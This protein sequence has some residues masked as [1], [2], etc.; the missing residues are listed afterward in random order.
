[1]NRAWRARRVTASVVP[2]VELQS[3]TIHSQMT[4][5]YLPGP[6]NESNDQWLELSW[7]EAPVRHGQRHLRR[8]D[9][10]WNRTI[11]LQRQT[12]AGVWEEIGEQPADDG[13]LPWP[14]SSSTPPSWRGPFAS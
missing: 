6:L 10:L 11:R 4:M 3:F 12:E 13:T 5:V 7:Q 9:S 14:A 2:G 8:D 1:M